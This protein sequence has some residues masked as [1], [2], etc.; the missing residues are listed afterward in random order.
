[1]VLSPNFRRTV[2][3]TCNFIDQHTALV[4]DGGFHKGVGRAERAER[5]GGD[6]VKRC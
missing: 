3:R 5:G 2:P 1:M 6:V 4:Y